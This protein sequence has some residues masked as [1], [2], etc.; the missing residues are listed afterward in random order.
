MLSR[1]RPRTSSSGSNVRL[2]NSTTAASSASL[3]LALRG[4]FG[5]MGA[6]AVVVWR[7]HLATVFSFSP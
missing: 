7:R 4:F 3:S 5:P 6:S 1:R 2:R